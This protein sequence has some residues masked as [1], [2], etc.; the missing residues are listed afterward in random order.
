MTA[1]D[2]GPDVL[3]P[4]FQA[5]TLPLPDDD[6]GPVV[7]TLVRYT[8]VGRELLRPAKAVLYVHGWSD[9]FFQREL[10]E[11][12]HQ[13][14]AGFY[15]LDLRKH[16]RS[17]RAH[18]TPAYAEDLRE[19]D[20]DL[21]AALAV[22][23]AEL[24]RWARVA[25]MGHSTGGLIAVLWAHRNPGRVASLVLNS[26][27][28]ELQ[29]SS[30]LRTLSTPV[31][32]QLA[33]F[34]PKNPLPNLDPGFYSRTIRAAEDGEWEFDERWRPTPAFAV[35]AGWL[36]AVLTGHAQVARGLAV[37]VPIL[38]LASS[39]SVI[40]PRWSEEM[41]RADVV[42]DVE[43]LARRAVQLGPLVTVVR[44]DGGLHDLA[45]SPPPVRERFYAEMA[46]WSTVYAWS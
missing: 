14:G 24:G 12:W 18:Q 46:R 35:R 39:R 36:H 7:A 23:R 10:A 27:W 8:P 28:L 4:D 15:A 33:R 25:L 29:G 1:E 45:L 6:E 37:D 26:P 21:E 30:L 31:I 3:G 34:Q 22:M 40:S 38:M 16:G 20:A 44:I 5:R 11:H 13:Q 32:E 9:Y 17:L 2:W 19:Y 42:L 43:L 41:R